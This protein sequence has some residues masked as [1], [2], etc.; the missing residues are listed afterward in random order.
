MS[1]AMVAAQAGSNATLARPE[2][3][4]AP[5][6]S[7]ADAPIVDETGET[8]QVTPPD[9]VQEVSPNKD[10]DPPLVQKA[11]PVSVPPNVEVTASDVVE[12]SA[13]PTAEPVA[14]T[15]PLTAEAVPV[16][17]ASQPAPAD[18]RPVRMQEVVTAYDAPVA[19]PLPA[20]K[21]DKVHA[22]AVEVTA[23]ADVAVTE[24]E[25]VQERR[26][27]AAKPMRT[28]SPDA[29]GDTGEQAQSSAAAT[30]ASGE[31]ASAEAR[32]GDA[33]D[34]AGGGPVGTPAPD[35]INQLRFWLDR[36]KTYPREARRRRMQG[37]VY[38]YFRVA[39]DGRVLDFEIRRSSGHILLDGEAEAMLQRAQPLPP[40]TD[41]MKGGYLDITVPVEF[42]LR[43]N[44]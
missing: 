16:V 17:P 4:E 24:V 37:M 21:P 20:R 11:S 8:A 5:R 29:G 34:V 43:G 13:P 42:S 14:T 10:A 38:L 33:V 32:H 36:N 40:F 15:I 30:A 2:M 22:R 27:T 6:A 25:V 3:A 12:T 18:T 39:R 41:N 35:Y 19:P 44:S 28:A 7:P 31:V 26:E 1:L 23:A 9:D